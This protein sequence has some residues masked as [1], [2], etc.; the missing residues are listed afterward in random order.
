MPTNADQAVLN[1]PLFK[2]P[3]ELRDII[4][5]YA[6][7]GDPKTTYEKYDAGNPY[8]GLSALYNV[9]E[10]PLLHVCQTIR[11]EALEFFLARPP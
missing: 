4:Y 7:G 11:R 2:L 1:S 6:V 3:P 8:I 10:P 9:Q 5:E